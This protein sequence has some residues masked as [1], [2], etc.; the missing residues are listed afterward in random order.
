MLSISELV[1][2]HQD[3]MASLNNNNEAVPCIPANDF[4]IT[5][6]FLNRTIP[7]LLV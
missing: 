7:P 2:L 4:F 5:V 3:K 1:L 6:V